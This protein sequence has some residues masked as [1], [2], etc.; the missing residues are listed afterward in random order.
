MADGVGRGD[1]T[2]ARSGKNGGFARL[3]PHGER[4]AVDA[5]SSFPDSPDVG[6][7]AQVL[8]RAETHGPSRPAR[9]TPLASSRLQRR[10]L[11]D[12]QPLA[13][14][15]AAG[16]D[17]LAATFGGHPGT[18]TNLAGALLAVRAECRF[19]DVKRKRGSVVPIRT[20]S[21]KGAVCGEFSK[22]NAAK[23][24][25]E[26]RIE[27]TGVGPGSV[28]SGDGVKRLRFSRRCFSSRLFRPAVCTPG[29]RDRSRD[30]ASASGRRPP[31]ATRADACAV[32]RSSAGWISRGRA[33]HRCRP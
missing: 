3:P 26:R 5:A 9:W 31:C 1:H 2:D 22:V 33:S 18:V 16:F 4:P 32:P 27:R 15:E 17:D 19:H 29:A 21:V 13:T 24:A 28:A 30:W 10:Q 6:L 12:G 14:L 11:D 20:G 23:F 25:A 7:T 8:F